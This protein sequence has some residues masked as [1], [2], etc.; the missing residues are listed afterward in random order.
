MHRVGGILKFCS[1]V[2]YDLIS[3]DVWNTLLSSLRSVLTYDGTLSLKITF[4]VK[5][6]LPV[7]MA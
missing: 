1:Q 2:S 3:Y 7:R 6:G 5:P 4:S